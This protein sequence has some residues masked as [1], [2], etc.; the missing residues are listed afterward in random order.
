V[1]DRRGLKKKKRRGGMKGGKTTVTERDTNLI[2][3]IPAERTRRQPR[4]EQKMG[5]KKII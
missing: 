1:G 2:K 5:K 4:V 3:G